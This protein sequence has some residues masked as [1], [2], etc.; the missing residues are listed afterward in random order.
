MKYILTLCG[1]GADYEPA[2]RGLGPVV[3]A[4]NAS[5]ALEEAR[6]RDVELLIADCSLLA[7]EEGAALASFIREKAIPMVLTLSRRDELARAAELEAEDYL[8][9]PFTADELASRAAFRLGRDGVS[10]TESGDGLIR[11]GA[12]TLDPLRRKVEAEG[13]AVRLTPTEYRILELLCSNRGQ[14]FSA[15]EIYCRVWNESYA[16]GD[17]TVAVHI[18][19]IREKIEENPKR[20]KFIK[21]VW[22]AG[23]KVE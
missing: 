1:R 7:G 15:S 22:S 2:L 17:N 6:R 3:G 8:L 5:R 16:V 21:S 18:R 14:I 11:V 12:L 10:L 20:P 23:Y 9:M 19:H 13:R 4:A